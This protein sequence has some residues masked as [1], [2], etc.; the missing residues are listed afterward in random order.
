MPKMTAPPKPAPVKRRFTAVEIGVISAIVVLLLIVVIP[1]VLDDSRDPVKEKEVTLVQD[2]IRRY[3]Q[4]TGVYPTFATVAAPGKEAASPWVDGGAP[5]QNSS[6]AHAGINFEAK[7]TRGD[8]TVSFVPDYISLRPRY[9][10]DVAN[11]GT[12]R[13]R[14]A[15]DGGV[16]IELDGRSY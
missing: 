12:R 16:T 9:A 8:Q 1:V 15:A 11:D 3:K 13:W 2:A 14:I 10:G 6:P 7:A 5:A 4:E